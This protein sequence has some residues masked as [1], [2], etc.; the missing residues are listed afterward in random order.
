MAWNKFKRFKEGPQNLHEL[1]VLSVYNDPD[2]KKEASR[3]NPK[4]ANAPERKKLARKYAVTLE[5]IDW[6]LG[7]LYPTFE[8][9]RNSDAAKPFQVVHNT[10]Y[11]KQYVYIRFR[12]NIT[13]EDYMMSWDLIMSRFKKMPDYKSKNKLPEEYGIV[14]AIF[15]ARLQKPRPSFSEIF[16]KYQNGELEGFNEH[17]NYF[18]SKDSLERYYNRYKPTE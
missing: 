3:L 6:Y 18:S 14:Y 1:H 15:K 17:T 16:I 8:L 13:K 12:K 7:P 11:D 2:F 4:S 10:D 5:E 9:D